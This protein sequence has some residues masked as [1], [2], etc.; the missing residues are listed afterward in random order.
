MTFKIR[1]ENIE[2]FQKKILTIEGFD[3]TLYTKSGL[4]WLTLSK[5]I[6]TITS[7]STSS[8]EEMRYIMDRK[9]IRILS[10]TPLSKFNQ[11]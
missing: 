8:V 1:T 3:V 11:A 7:L 6:L 2:S 4:K 9:C 5:K 10:Y